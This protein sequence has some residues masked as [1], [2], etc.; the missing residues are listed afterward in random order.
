[1]Q[2]LLIAGT[3]TEVGKTMLT[4][5]LL[6]Y[7][8]THLQHLNWGIMKLMQTGLGDCEFYQQLFPSLEVV[9]PIYLKTPV[10]P[11]EAAAIEDQEINLGIVWQALRG[12]QSAKDVVLIEALGGLGSPVTEE[13]TVAD[14]AGDWRLPVVIV[15]P[16][17]LGAI[18]Q[19][20]ANVALARSA[21]IQ[22]RGI[23]LNCTQPLGDEEIAKLAPIGLIE[24]LTHT[25]V[26]GIIPYLEKT[27]DLSQLARIAADLELERLLPIPV[28]L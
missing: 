7:A 28:L 21:K 24:S 11:P 4:A 16:I 2:A 9:T 10:A 23:V 8:Q 27:T 1:M 19:A 15:V 17:K 25:P 22:L 6:A 5:S 12:L 13:L 3:D 18:A 26:L 14:L 20:V